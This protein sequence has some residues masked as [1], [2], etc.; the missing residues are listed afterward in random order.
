MEFFELGIGRIHQLISDCFLSAALRG[1]IFALSFL[2]A[3]IIIVLFCKKFNFFKREN[4]AM[5]FIA[6]FYYFYIPLIFMIGGFAIG[7]SLATRDFFAKETKNSISPLMKLIFPTYQ[8]HVNIHWDRVVQT[9]MTFNQT[10]DEYVEEIKFTPRNDEFVERIATFTANSMVPKITRWGIESVVSSAKD[11]AIK[12]S[13][14]QGYIETSKVKALLIAHSM[15]MFNYPPGLWEE[16]NTRLE[17]KTV[18]FFSGITGNIFL[19]FLLFLLFPVFETAL[20]RFFLKRKIKTVLDQ[21]ETKDRLKSNQNEQQEE[22]I[23]EF[24]KITREKTPVTTVDIEIP[25]VFEN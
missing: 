17:E 25:K 14:E 19:F 11:I 3:G 15:S 7:A 12:Q 21:N 1:L 5:Q 23:E 2:L 4:G 20:Y 13:E 22:I 18:Y 24:E 16:A 10:V 6:R 9:R 8:S